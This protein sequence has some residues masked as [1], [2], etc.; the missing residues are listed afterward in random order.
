MTIGRGSCSFFV[1]RFQNKCPS[2]GGK[3]LQTQSALFETCGLLTFDIHTIGTYWIVVE[4]ASYPDDE[5]MPP[6][7]F[8]D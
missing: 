1:V 7:P 6:P 8:V 3:V 2:N 5:V 4:G